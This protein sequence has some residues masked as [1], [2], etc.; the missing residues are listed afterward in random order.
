MDFVSLSGGRRSRRIPTGV[1]VCLS[2]L[3]KPPAVDDEIAYTENVST[4][5]ARVISRSAF[6]PGEE[7]RVTSV[8]DGI[9]I[10]ASVVFCR[11]LDSGRFYV[12]LNF[13]DQAV[14]W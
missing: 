11:R 8:K 9:A 12:G 5:G 14:L 4:H 6:Q 3:Q 7:V 1:A 10:L 2:R 13:H